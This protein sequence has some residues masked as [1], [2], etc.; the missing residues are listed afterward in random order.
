M[1]EK[2]RE[3]AFSEIYERY[4]EKLYVYV[5]NRTHSADISF[6]ITQDVFVSI[7]QRRHEVVFHSSLSGYMFASVRYKILRY[8]KS[9]IIREEYCRDYT[10][11]SQSLSD[12]SNEE[13]VNLHQLEEAIEKNIREL[14]KRCQEIFRMSRYQNL[15]IKEIADKL[16]ISHK[17]VE[18]Q[19]TI[20][21]SHLRKSLGEFML[22]VLFLIS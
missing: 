6:E 3:E 16:N 13:K 17:T 2:G 10:L 11:F 15:S 20:A 5:F 8:I 4:W 1:L 21:L 9:S 18:N 7:W 19:L 22:L 14:P 12:N